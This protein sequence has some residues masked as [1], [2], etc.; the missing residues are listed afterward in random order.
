MKEK[1]LKKVIAVLLFVFISFSLLGFY[2]MDTE[3]ATYKL[4]YK[5]LSSYKLFH[6]KWNSKAKFGSGSGTTAI[7][8]NVSAKL[9]YVNGE[10]AY[11]IYMPDSTDDGESK[12]FNSDSDSRT[13]WVNKKTGGY[14]RYA[15]CAAVEFY[16]VDKK[17]SLDGISGSSKL[18]ALSKTERMLLSQGFVWY[19][20]YA[21]WA[22]KE[23]TYAMAIDNISGWS[24]AKQYVL[25]DELYTAAKEVL[26]G[27]KVS[28]QCYKL[29]IDGNSHQPVMVLNCEELPQYEK[30]TYS[31]AGEDSEKVTLNIVKKDSNT[32]KGLAG[33]EFS[34][35]C[36]GEKTGVEVTDSEGKIS[37]IYRRILKTNTY[38]AV[39]SYVTNWEKLSAQYRE[40]VTKN[41]Y[42]QNKTKALQAAQTE[43]NAKISAELLNLKSKSHEWMITEVT[44]PFGHSISDE[45]PITMVEGE[46][47]TLEYTFYNPE[48]EREVH[49]KKISSVSDYGV[50]A[51]LKDAVYSL[52]AKEDILGS[53]NQTVIYK[54]DSLV[55][56]IR[57]DKEGKASVSNLYPGKYYLKESE[58]PKG[59]LLSD[60]EFFVDLSKKDQDI[61]I[62]EE[63]IVGKI[64]IRKTY[65]GDKLPEYQAE[66]ELYNSKGV[67]MDT[68]VTDTSG[69]GESKELPYGTYRI[70]QIKG[71]EGKGMPL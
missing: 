54:K 2:G 3:A 35:A 71:R 28:N 46:E 41:G 19:M 5:K 64:K 57:T 66:F 26:P 10:Y 11:C 34:F 43:V 6:N 4:T 56:T 42:Y 49:L 62:T 14:P 69:V 59:F 67:L 33:A 17:I 70:H 51:T 68:V 44:A 20:E 7:K 61:E 55:T 15:Y 23:R 53:D 39:K 13:E 38:S 16:L 60:E 32:N 58:A 1:L 36:D 12:L 30:V 48:E 52:Y 18:L 24:A 8:N 29:K 50:D 37:Y 31:N 9:H 25:F 63:P 65:S 22:R 45:S 21:G 27:L 40:A 47:K